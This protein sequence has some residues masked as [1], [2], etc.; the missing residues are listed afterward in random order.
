VGGF[1]ASLGSLALFVT[2]LA[3]LLA[4]W[5]ALPGLLPG[6]IFGVSPFLVGPVPVVDG[7]APAFGAVVFD[8]SAG[9]LVFSLSAAFGLT[10]FTDWGRRTAPPVFPA[11][12]SFKAR[13]FL[14]PSLS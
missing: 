3:T 2:G 14:S 4:V 13:L 6:L 7:S 12:L 1:P 8:V 10:A 5:P 11:V 9:L